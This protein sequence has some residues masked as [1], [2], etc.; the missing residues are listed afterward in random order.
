M[1][2]ETTTNQALIG[3]ASSIH[4][5]VSNKTRIPVRVRTCNLHVPPAPRD[6]LGHC[7]YYYRPLHEEYV[8]KSGV[9]TWQAFKA[10]TSDW[11]PWD[12]VKVSWQL[13]N[14][15][16]QLLKANPGTPE[17]S[18]HANFMMRH[19]GCGHKPPAYYVSFGYYYCSIYGEALRPKLSTH[20]KAWLDRARLLLQLKMEEGL[21]QN[22]D[23]DVIDMP[24]REFPGASV[25]MI[26]P[27]YQLEVINTVFQNFAFNTHVPAYLEAGLADLG[28]FDLAAIAASPIS[29]SGPK[30]G[31]G[32][33]PGKFF[34]ETLGKTP[35]RPGM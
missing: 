8:E 12:N 17:W 13:F 7:T 10:W 35:K 16:D 34:C 3:E 9:S 11:N 33:K 21:K 20:G 6:V 31:C 32:S 27:Q 4:T 5:P 19:I 25:H 30:P 18:R 23:G 22:M 15:R 1:P 26:V 14:N 2:D 28:L 29:K 24:S